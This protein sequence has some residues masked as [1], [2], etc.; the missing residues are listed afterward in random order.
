MKIKSAILL[1]LLAF[2]SGCVK[3]AHYHAY[4]SQKF[5]IISTNDLTKKWVSKN[6][7][8]KSIASDSGI[9][10]SECEVSLSLLRPH[11]TFKITAQKIIVDCMDEKRISVFY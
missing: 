11:S 4:I 10:L 2:L 3:S 7:K 9:A 8:E 5:E 1:I 6:N